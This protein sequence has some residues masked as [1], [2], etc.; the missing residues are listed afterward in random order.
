MS[1]P[2]MY[3]IAIMYVS[4]GVA[5]AWEGKLE[6]TALTFSWASGNFILGYISK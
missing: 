6:W 3:A 4:A 5:F 1:Q 2:F